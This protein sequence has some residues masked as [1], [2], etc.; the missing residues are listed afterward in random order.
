MPRLWVVCALMWTAA[1]A[2]ALNLVKSINAQTVWSGFTV[3]FSKAIST[4]PTLPQNQDRITDNV[5]LTR[6]VNK[7]IF[8]IRQESEYDQGDFSSPEGTEWATDLNN[9]GETI[10]AENWEDLAFTTWVSA[11]GGE[12][13]GQLP[14]RLIG[15]D[16]VVH[17]ITDDI[18]LDLRFTNWSGGGGAFSY[19]R[20]MG[21]I[22]PPATTGDYNGNGVVDA[23]D[24]VIWR[25][26]LN[27]TV[28][29]PGDGADGNRS[30]VI[31]QGDYEFWRMQFGDVVPVP[32]SGSGHIATVPEPATSGLL[33]FATLVALGHWPRK[34][35]QDFHRVEG[36]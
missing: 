12:G 26:T 9:P 6:A 2:I 10:A 29:E 36:L 33:L 13:S 19:Q 18:Y 30:G 21:A 1:A 35:F 17:L 16:A 5:W 15:R 34:R 24:Y 27:Q 32:V 14:S 23:A 3:E 22:T 8:N 25:K 11:Y 4:D 7:G 28:P 20:A 31:D